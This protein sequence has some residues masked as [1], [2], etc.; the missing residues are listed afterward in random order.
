MTFALWLSRRLGRRISGHERLFMAVFA[1]Q[2][3]DRSHVY[4][5]PY[6]PL[7]RRWP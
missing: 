1:Q 2:P 5:P 7:W 4:D 6:W 3:A